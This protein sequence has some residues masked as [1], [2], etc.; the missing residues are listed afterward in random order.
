[1][2][3]VLKISDKSIIKRNARIY[4][5]FLF[6]PVGLLVWASIN[7][8]FSTD[9]SSNEMIAYA[10]IGVIHLAFMLYNRKLHINEKVMLQKDGIITQQ[11]NLIP[12]S[13]IVNY[14]PKK[15]NKWTDTISISIRSGQEVAFTKVKEKTNENTIDFI[16]FGNHLKERVSLES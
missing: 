3:I 7:N 15:F 1:M 6:L 16:A 8:W 10:V 5:A 2:E 9:A 11:F 12:F 13:E 4:C 14:S